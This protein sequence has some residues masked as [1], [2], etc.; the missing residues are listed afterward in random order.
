M[1]EEPEPVA[2][3]D[4]APIIDQ[5]PEPVTEPPPALVVEPDLELVIE[6]IKRRIREHES[7]LSQNRKRTEIALIHPILEFMEWDTSDPELVIPAYRGEDYALVRNSRPQAILASRKLHSNYN[8][9]NK[10][11]E[12]CESNMILYLINTDGDHWQI[13]SALSPKREFPKVYI[14]KQP[15]PEAATSLYRIFDAIDGNIAR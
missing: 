8:W 14:T 6:Q 2:E 13:H 4:A 5:G 10:K 1:T 3:K 11:L 15:T 12:Y 7:L 9:T